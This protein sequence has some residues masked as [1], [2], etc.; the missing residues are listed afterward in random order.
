MD[1]SFRRVQVSFKTLFPCL[2][3]SPTVQ[4]WGRCKD[5]ALIQ[6]SLLG[7]SPCGGKEEVFLD[8]LG[9]G[10]ETPKLIFQW[11]RTCP[12]ADVARDGC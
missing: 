6:G 12:A 5:P 11:V 4:G 1:L 9:A 8:V 7:C 2:A 3:A 10:M